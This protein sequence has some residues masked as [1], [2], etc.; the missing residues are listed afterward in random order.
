MIGEEVDGK[1]DQEG[2][3][4]RENA[5]WVEGGIVQDVLRS[6]MCVDEG[7]VCLDHSENDLPYNKFTIIQTKRHR[8]I[9]KHCA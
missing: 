7:V 4:G 1:G 6:A 8:R 2:G 3:K 5:C 9:V